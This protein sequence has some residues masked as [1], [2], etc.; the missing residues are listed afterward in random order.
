MGKSHNIIRDPSTPKSVFK[1]LWET[2]KNDK[3][4]RGKITNKKKDG[5]R[6]IVDAVISPIK[7]R[8]G[9]TIGYNA[10]RQDI[11]LDMQIKNLLNNIPIGILSFDVDFNIKSGYS[12]IC[13]KMLNKSYLEQYKIDEVLFDNDLAQKKVFIKGIKYLSES[14]NCEE[15]KL[16]ASLLPNEVKINNTFFKLE[17]KLLNEKEIMLI[18]TDLTKTKELE[19]KFL[20]EQQKARMII[21]IASHRKSFIEL[22]ENFK[23]FL[24]LIDSQNPSREDCEQYLFQLHTF[25]GIFAQKEM[26]NIVQAIHCVETKIK[27]S[28]EDKSLQSYG[29]ILKNSNLKEEF[30]KDLKIVTETLGY[31]FIETIN[32]KHQTEI[33]TKLTNKLITLVN[34]NVVINSSLLYGLRDDILSI[35]YES[36]HIM[37]NSYPALIQKI[38]TQLKKNIN[39]VEII[40]DYNIFVPPTFKPFINSLVHIFRNSIDHGIE[41]PDE[42][43]FL[44]KDVNATIK[45]E[46]FQDKNNIVIKISDDGRGIDVDKIALKALQKG[47]ITK[48]KL[49]TL[50][51]DEKL[52]FI[53]SNHITTQEKVSKISGQ[54]IGLSALKNELD[55]LNGEVKVI[56]KPQK[57]VEFIFSIP[58]KT[59]LYSLKTEFE[60]ILKSVKDYFVKELNFDIISLTNISKF[61]PNKDIVTIHFS[62]GL[63]AIAIM[64]LDED[65]LNNLYDLMIP[66]G[67]SEYES[68]LIKQDIPKEILNTIISY[69][70]KDFSV[71]SYDKITISTPKVVKKQDYKNLLQNF[72]T[73]IYAK[74]VTSKGKLFVGLMK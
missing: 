4:W 14:N 22:I 71:E 62:G 67:V 57:G 1:H 31:D 43:M 5:S 23:K 49:D 28:L 47:L 29:K 58:L 27:Q 48:E 24:K 8:Y 51:E 32:E 12:K 66:L 44:G 64:D 73:T 33:I 10:V 6:Y 20:F 55:K 38:A 7:N 50:S 35:N 37:F 9:K 65:L 3:I 54:G 15:K 34:K 16:Y 56:N 69:T 25:K 53:F 41:S 68:N 21:A 52:K 26:V 46:F 19:S 74:V 70:L 40:G 42:R 11:T 39:P 45:C 60:I 30:E 63:E 18:L 61:I 17:Y 72:Q 59:E 13:E 2:I 36:L